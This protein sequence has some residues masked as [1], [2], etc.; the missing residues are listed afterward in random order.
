M[1][2]HAGTR[3]PSSLAAASA[4]L[5]V[6]TPLPRRTWRPVPPPAPPGAA[7]PGP[8]LPAPGPSDQAQ[9]PGPQRVW[10]RWA[11]DLDTLRRLVTG[12]RQLD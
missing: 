10:P 4:V 7:L 2:L 8:A 3:P 11:S 12:L 5:D 9:A 1:T 6:A